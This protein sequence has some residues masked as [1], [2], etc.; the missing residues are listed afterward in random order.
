MPKDTRHPHR[1][2]KVIELV[3]TSTKDFEDAIRTALEDASASLRDIHGAH[4]VGQ[5]VKCE[6]GKITEYRVDLKVSFGIERT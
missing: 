2:A 6:N 5:N 4:V 3:G 1:T